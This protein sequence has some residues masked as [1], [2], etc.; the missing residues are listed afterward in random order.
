MR[1]VLRFGTD[2]WRGRIGFEFTFA[3]LARATAATA[4]HFL[5][6]GLGAAVAGYDRR[7]LSPEFAQH[8][9]HVLEARGVRTVLADGDVPTPA[10]S[11]AVAQRAGCFGVM[12]TASHNPP[13]F[14]GFKVKEP[15]GASLEDTSARDI[16]ARLVRLEAPAPQVAAGAPAAAGTPAPERA[17]LVTP[18]LAALA[19]RVD[20][21][22]LRSRSWT[23]LVDSMHGSGGRLLE[24]L[25]SGGRAQIVTLRAGRDV[26]FGGHGPE[27]IE[28]HLRDAARAL[29]A[30]EADVGLATDGDADRLGALDERGEFV[31]SQILTPLLALHL[32]EKRGFHGSIAKTFAHTI[33]LDHLARD[34]GI[35]LHVRPIGFKHLG[36]IMRVEPVVVAGEESGGIG[37]GGFIPERDGLLAGLLVLEALAARDQTLGQAAA[38]VRRRFGDFHYRRVDLR[39]EPES[40]RAAVEALAAAL[41]TRLGGLAVAGA[42]RLDG[43]KCLLGDDGWI[44]FRQSGTE[45]VLRVYAEAR[46]RERLQPLLD[47]GVRAL[48]THLPAG[49]VSARADGGK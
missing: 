34:L 4:D 14:N 8:A 20:L 37:V 29:A 23:V 44:L 9:A 18:H 46:G 40:G 35:A 6:R 1:E 43:L 33:L 21:G 30:G 5:A 48:A 12:I 7:F 27:P 39:S 49:I 13:Q 26:L 45:P 2:G 22:R 10:L 32:I 3:N 38:A 31:G 15:D 28:E 19:E 17:D 41:P 42:D 16:E 47:D 25:L 11:W 24:R 36:A